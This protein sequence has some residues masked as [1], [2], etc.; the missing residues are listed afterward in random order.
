MNQENIKEEASS[1]AHPPILFV[2][3]TR[4]AAWCRTEQLLSYYVRNGYVS[5]AMSMRGHSGSEGRERLRWL[6]LAAYVS[7]VAQV[8]GRMERLPVLIGHST[9]GMVVHKYLELNKAPGAVLSASVQ[10]KE[11]ARATVRVAHR[12]PL[13]FIK[14][15][16]TLSMLQVRSSR[17]RRQYRFVCI[18]PPCWPQ[19]HSLFI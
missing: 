4:H 1:D 16:L 11:V 10:P 2:H 19:Q 17:E 18:Y 7:D 9:G 13:A 5:H 12:Y 3:V 6:S 15:I 14:S 8:V